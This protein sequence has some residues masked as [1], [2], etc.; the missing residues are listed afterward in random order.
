[1]LTMT[2]SNA[3]G[4]GIAFFLIAAV[5]SLY[6]YSLFDGPGLAERSGFWT[7]AFIAYFGLMGALIVGGIVRFM[8]L[9]SRGR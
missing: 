6:C 7:A 8:W 9:V 4:R 1:M 5:I 2:E 3:T